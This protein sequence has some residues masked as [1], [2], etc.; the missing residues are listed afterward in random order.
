MT[1]EVGTSSRPA[2]PNPA[3]C[4]RWTHV[5]C[6]ASGHR[7]RV[8]AHNAW[9]LNHVRKPYTIAGVV[10][11]QIGR[12]PRNVG[13]SAGQITQLDSVDRRRQSNRP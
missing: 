1:S 12:S 9:R 7:F 8:G 2:T 10:S 11:D 13:K 4:V 6:T 5:R 3:F